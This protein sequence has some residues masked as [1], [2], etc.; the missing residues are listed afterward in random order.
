MDLTAVSLKG[1]LIY[2]DGPSGATG[3][4]ASTAQ[5]LK[6]GNV[7]GYQHRATEIPGRRRLALHVF[8]HVVYARK[9]NVQNSMLMALYSPHM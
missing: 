1:V 3:V 9:M 4:G 6:L 2:I 7:L 5:A 8:C